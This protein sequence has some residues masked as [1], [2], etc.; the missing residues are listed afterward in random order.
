MTDTQALRQALIKNL[1]SMA[2]GQGGNADVFSAE[3]DKQVAQDFILA[4][5]A[6]TDDQA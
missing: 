6:E 5:P 1:G 2:A 4:G 3:L